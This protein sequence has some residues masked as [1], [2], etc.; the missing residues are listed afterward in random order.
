MWFWKQK[1]AHRPIRVVDIG[2]EHQ[3]SYF[4]C[5]EEE[6]PDMQDAGTLKACW[7][8]KY[9][10]RGL[11]VKLALDDQ[12][13]PV[14]MIQYLPIEASHVEGEGL[15]MILC[16][17][18]H[19]HDLGKGNRQGHGMGKA[20]LEAAEA[21]AKARGAR[22]MAA[23]GLWIPV[24]MKASWFKK[25]GYKKADRDGM[26]LLMFKPFVK[27]AKAPR[28]MRP[29][30]PLPSVQ[31]KVTL[32]AFKN[33]WCPAQ[34]I[35]YERAKRAALQFGER[36]VFLEYDTTEPTVMTEWG[37]SDGIFLDGKPLVW[38]PPKSYQDIVRA[39]QQRL[40]KLNKRL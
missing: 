26:A 2:A 24:W 11:R 34:N 22:G 29:N 38:G 9:K 20:L 28:W 35:N 39:I 31:G 6:H 10:E 4:H 8:D 15:Y 12:G 17:W 1:E 37:I 25:Q 23:W 27:E 32:V 18:V 14:G 5:L 13:L 33:G 21:D 36:V 16:I 30:K 19:G 7:F 40:K 3:H